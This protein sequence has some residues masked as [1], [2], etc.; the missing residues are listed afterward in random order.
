ML[1]FLHMD[2]TNSHG[3]LFRRF[4]L[5]GP[6][7]FKLEMKQQKP[8]EEDILVQAMAALKIS[9]KC[10]TRRHR[11]YDLPTWGQIKP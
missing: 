7:T 4:D 1:L 11:P 3:F 5:R 9:K 10:C 2:P 8:Q 6:P